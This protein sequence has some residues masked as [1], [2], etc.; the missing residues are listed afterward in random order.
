MASFVIA[1]PEMMAAAA[2]NL[3]GIG[4]AVRAANL[5]AAGSTT[6]VLAA[7]Q[8]EVSAAIAE[9]FGTYGRDFQTL[10]AQ[11]TAFHEQFVAALTGAGG[12]YGLA[13]AA[14][15]S[16][17]Q[18]LEDDVLGVINAPTNLLLGRPL[19]GNGTDGASGTGQAGGPGGILI[20]NG[21]NGGQGSGGQHGGAGG[22]GGRFFGS[23]G[24]DGG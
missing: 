9:M 21:G 13:E 23:N 12:A 6:Q 22:S 10:S 19:I 3:T 11:A 1:T 14:N 20:G 18:T 8:D 5:A 17:L 15:V 16:P 2:G 4:S 7:A 24:L